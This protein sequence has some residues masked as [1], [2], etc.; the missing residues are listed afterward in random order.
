MNTIKST[1]SILGC[2]WLGEPLAKHLIGQGYTVKGSTTSKNK[3]QRLELA[4][5]NPFIINLDAL[6]NNCLTFLDSEILIIAIT[7]KNNDGFRNFIHQIENSKIK[8]VLFV[9][10]TSVYSESNKII[11]EDADLKPSSLVKIENLFKTN[12]AF[13]STI[14]RFA[15]LIGYDRQPGK[16]YPE[17]KKIS[18]PKGPVNMVH[19]D[20]CILI[21]EQI[22]KKEIWNETFNV[23]ADTHPSRR[24]FYTKAALDI[25]HNAPDFEEMGSNEQKIV[26]NQKLKNILA[27]EFK[28]SD[29]LD[30]NKNNL[31]KHI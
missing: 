18:N 19:R 21:I 8:K 16:F 12:D 3:I 5:I 2:G 22:I 23:C 15:G 30:L 7:S 28:Y 24:E 27:Y 26:S 10:S 4:G 29:L 6:T 25:G 13:Q 17:G 14:I 9:S 31:G 1:V 20:D 11:T